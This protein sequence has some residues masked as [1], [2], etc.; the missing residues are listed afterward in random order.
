VVPLALEYAVWVERTPEALARY[1]EPIR[2]ADH[3]GLDG[4]AWTRLIEDRLTQ[5]LD[6]LN[7]DAMSRDPGRFVTVIGGTAGVGG[8]YDVWRRAKALLT[9]RRFDGSHGAEDRP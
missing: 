5:T 1:G 4:K 2:V 8:V 7:A 9:G 6:A 3:V